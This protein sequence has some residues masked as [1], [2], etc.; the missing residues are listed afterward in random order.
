[1]HYKSYLVPVTWARRHRL[2]DGI[3]TAEGIHCALDRLAAHGQIDETRRTISRS[4]GIHYRANEVPDVTYISE[5]SQHTIKIVAQALA[6]CTARK[7]RKSDLNR[8]W[9][10]WPE[11]ID[12][13]VHLAAEWSMIDILSINHSNWA[14]VSTGHAAGRPQGPGEDTARITATRGRS[15][16]PAR[17]IRVRPRAYIPNPAGRTGRTFPSLY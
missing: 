9:R 11:E 2:I 14:N 6:S 5:R 4:P 8:I 16:K 15:S 7:A 3:P 10:N 17:L 12:V 1:L 13:P